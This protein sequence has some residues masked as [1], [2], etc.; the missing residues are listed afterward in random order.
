MLFGAGVD[1]PVE[2]SI[3]C[4]AVPE[5]AQIFRSASSPLGC[6]LWAFQWQNLGPAAPSPDVWLLSGVTAHLPKKD[7]QL[8][9]A[10][11]QHLTSTGPS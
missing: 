3:V 11:T 9:Q 6:F 1:A 8:P 2:F 5:S 10:Q 4:A 7:S